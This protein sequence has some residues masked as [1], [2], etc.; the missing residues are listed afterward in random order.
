V[1]EYTLVAMQSGSFGHGYCEI[2][3]YYA[4]EFSARSQSLRIEVKP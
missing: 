1:I 4:P 3:S 2:Q